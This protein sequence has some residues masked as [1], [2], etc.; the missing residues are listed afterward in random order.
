MQGAMVVHAHNGGIDHLY[1]RVLTGGKRIHD[2]VLE[3]AKAGA[4]RAFLTLA[5]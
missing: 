4:R 5:N 1:R 2:L 3:S